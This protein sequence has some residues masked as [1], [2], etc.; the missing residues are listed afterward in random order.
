[1]KKIYLCFTVVVFSLAALCRAD[2]EPRLIEV[3]PRIAIANGRLAT[4]LCTSLWKS[5]EGAWVPDSQQVLA[6]FK[7][8]KS[9]E[10]M[11]QI[12]QRA[13]PKTDMWPSLHRLEESRFQVFGIK[14]GG[15]N[16][17]FYDATPLDSDR[18]DLWLTD[19][20]SR[21]VWD[22]GAAYWW[23][24]LDTENLSVKSASRRPN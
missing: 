13:S 9:D 20:I 2:E 12:V 7:V 16:Y 4:A 6:G 22:G 23:V 24:L 1:V 19:C 17:M 21:S 3:S 8:I 14:I 10:G 5:A 11:R 15:R 18:I